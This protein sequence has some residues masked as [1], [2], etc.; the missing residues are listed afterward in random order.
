MRLIGLK[1]LSLVV[2]DTGI[3]SK[4]LMMLYIAGYN[5]LFVACRA[6]NSISVLSSTRVHLI[7]N[8][9]SHPQNLLSLVNL[10][11]RY[12]KIYQ[13]FQVLCLEDL[14]GLYKVFPPPP[15]KPRSTLFA[16]RFDISSTKWS[17]VSKMIRY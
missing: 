1:D 17:K 9:Q 5:P 12:L 10:S 16:T 2:D 11:V 15:K 13:L 7:S 6:L 14:Q 8:A 4:I 3:I